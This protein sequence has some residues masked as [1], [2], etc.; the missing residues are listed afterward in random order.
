MQFCLNEFSESDK[1]LKHELGQCKDP[2][3]R[4]CLT[5]EVVGSNNSVK[6]KNVVLQNS[7][8]SVKTFR[9]NSNNLNIKK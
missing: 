7:M 9:D 1:S 4:L 5:Y 6:H 3:C 8:D 2:I